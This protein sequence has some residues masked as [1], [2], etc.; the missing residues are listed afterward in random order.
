MVQKVNTAE[1]VLFL[2]LYQHVQAQSFKS[3]PVL[4][5]VLLL[6]YRQQISMRAHSIWMEDNHRLFD[7]HSLRKKELEFWS[8]WDA[9]LLNYSSTWLLHTATAALRPTT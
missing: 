4:P 1:D 3:I 6:P 9:N 2:N 8:S 5:R 7:N